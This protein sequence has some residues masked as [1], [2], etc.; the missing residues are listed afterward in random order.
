MSI[1]SRSVRAGASPWAATIRRCP[2]G[3]SPGSLSPRSVNSIGGRSGMNMSQPAHERHQLFIAVLEFVGGTNICP[4]VSCA[5]ARN[6][7]GRRWRARSSPRRPFRIEHHQSAERVAGA[8]MS[9]S[10]RASW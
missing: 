8:R 9:C 3:Q 2:D 5:V 6:W 4:V 10:W 7:I 1:E